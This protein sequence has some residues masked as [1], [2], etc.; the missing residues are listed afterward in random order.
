MKGN[1]N[2]PRSYLDTFFLSLQLFAKRV[3]Y[4]FNELVLRIIRGIR[5]KIQWLQQHS[6]VAYG[7]VIVFIGLFVFGSQSFL[8]KERKIEL[9]AFPIIESN[10]K[11]YIK[12]KLEFK[13]LHLN[14]ISSNELMLSS[15]S[16]GISDLCYSSDSISFIRPS[17]NGAYYNGNLCYSFQY[18]YSIQYRKKGTYSWNLN[19]CKSN[20]TKIVPSTS[21][22]WRVRTMCSNNELPI[23]NISSSGNYYLSLEK[24]MKQNNATEAVMETFIKEDYEGVKMYSH[25]NKESYLTSTKAAKELGTP[26]I[27]YIPFEISLSSEKSA[28][29][30]YPII[31]SNPHNSISKTN[32]WN[33]WLLAAIL[34][35]LLLIIGFLILFYFKEKSPL[36]TQTY[37]IVATGP[38]DIIK[39]VRRLISL[40]KIDTALAR[41]VTSLSQMEAN[42]LKEQAILR[43]EII[44]L[45]FRLNAIRKERRKGLISREEAQVEENNIVQALLILLTNM[46]RDNRLTATA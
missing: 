33:N 19:K 2:F 39:E 45:Q 20:L 32:N 23:S 14:C 15:I 41:I 11:N 29:S 44:L 21:Y 16:E 5:G 13:I 25:I 9:S 28:T 4:S 35:A 12:Q 40:A 17:S 22:C 46:E 6:F 42:L 18:R 31:Y 38:P 24:K 3:R 8:N 43:D 1:N 10:E 30:S 26:V 7:L 34:T 37:A 27:R 36:E